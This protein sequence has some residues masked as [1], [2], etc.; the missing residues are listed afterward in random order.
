[1]LASSVDSDFLASD[2]VLYVLPVLPVLFAIAL[3][4]LDL[5]RVVV[6]FL[7]LVDVDGLIAFLGVGVVS[8]LMRTI[9]LIA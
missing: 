6:A 2:R 9:H 5:G 3:S 7:V 4:T 1:L 8:Y